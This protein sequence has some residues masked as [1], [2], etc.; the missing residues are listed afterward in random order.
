MSTRKE[1]DKEM[2]KYEEFVN[3]PLEERGNAVMFISFESNRR[4]MVQYTIDLEMPYRFGDEVVQCVCWIKV[5]PV[6][7]IPEVQTLQAMLQYQAKRRATTVE[8]LAHEILN[9]LELAMHSPFI[10]V[11]IYCKKY[12]V[13]VTVGSVEIESKEV[14]EV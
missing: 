12:K 11:N 9:N 1:K 3:T 2:R 7:R 8:L 14:T 5:R 6:D 13:N 10:E 4:F